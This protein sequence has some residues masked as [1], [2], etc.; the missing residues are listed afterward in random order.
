MYIYE[1]V[2]KRGPGT[3]RLTVSVKVLID[4]G[5]VIG[6]NYVGHLKC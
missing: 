2:F 1:S 6:W 5:E 3:G 4:P